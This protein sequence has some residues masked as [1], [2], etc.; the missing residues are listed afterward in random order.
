MLANMRASA[1]KMSSKWQR[2]PLWAKCSAT[3]TTVL[4][5]NILM[6]TLITLWTRLKL[7]SDD[8]HYQANLLAP[9]Q[10][11]RQNHGALKKGLKGMP[12]NH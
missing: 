4:G 2:M 12:I 1:T 8:S 3:L 6:L 11:R 7:R 10:Q 5:C 9:K